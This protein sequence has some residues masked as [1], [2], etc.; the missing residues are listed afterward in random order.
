MI[1]N[2]LLRPNQKINFIGQY[3]QQCSSCSVEGHEVW[4]KLQDVAN[5]LSEFSL[6]NNGTEMKTPEVC[7]EGKRTKH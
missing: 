5:W 3:F 2:F 6:N 7:L 4:N 1:L